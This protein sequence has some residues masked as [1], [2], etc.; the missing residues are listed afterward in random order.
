ML[1]K[2]FARR[3]PWKKWFRTRHFHLVRGVDYNGRTD[4]MAQQVYQAGKREG[5][6]LS[7][8]R[9]IASDNNSLSVLRQSEY[10]KRTRTPSWTN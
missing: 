5:Y 7:P 2:K 3:Y 1:N 8:V 9:E 10:R 6:L 4:T